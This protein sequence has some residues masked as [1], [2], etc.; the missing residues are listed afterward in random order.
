ML[1]VDADLRGPTL[2]RVLKLS[3]SWGLCDVLCSDNPINNIGTSQLVRHTDIQGL[4]LLPAGTTRESPSHLLYSPRLVEL[5]RRLMQEY[6][7]VLIDSPPMMHLADARALGRVANGVVLVL[8]SGQTTVAQAQLAVRRFVEDGT[9]VV[10]TILNGWDPKTASGTDY[11]DSYIQ[12][13]KQYHNGQ[14]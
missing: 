6:N 5:F 9:H 8:R 7:L 3:N 4:D 13:T 14:A 1:L 11:G 2:H 10:G 12:Y